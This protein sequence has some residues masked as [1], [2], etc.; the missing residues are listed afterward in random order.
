[1]GAMYVTQ[2]K[3]CNSVFRNRI[4][5]LSLQGLNPQK[6]YDYLQS[7]QDENE[8]A[9]VKTEDIKPSSIRRHLDR[10][11]SYEEAA[12]VKVAET[13]SRIDKSREMLHTDRKSVV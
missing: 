12:K 3:V 11:F 5:E 13:H 7:L 8:K 1:M 4:E 10:H 6:I 9:L 2:C